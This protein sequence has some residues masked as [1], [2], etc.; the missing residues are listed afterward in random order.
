LAVLSIISLNNFQPLSCF[1]ATVSLLAGRLLDDGVFP[2][3]ANCTVHSSRDR[4]NA[5]TACG[6]GTKTA[7]RENHREYFLLR[8]TKES[9]QMSRAPRAVFLKNDEDL[10]GHVAELLSDYHFEKVT[11]G[12]I[13]PECKLWSPEFNHSVDLYHPDE[14]IAIEIEKS[15]QK[16]V[17]DDIL[18]SSIH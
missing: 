5:S 6:S 2:E 11:T 16:R 3:L 7:G 1:I 14:R 12:G 10:D 13:N 15:Q 9:S 4:S 17:S 18:K 8:S